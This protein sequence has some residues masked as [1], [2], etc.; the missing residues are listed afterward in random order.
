MKKQFMVTALA[1]LMF[2]TIV[3]AVQ[4]NEGV[5]INQDENIKI[6][7]S[8]QLT[9]SYLAVYENDTDIGNSNFSLNQAGTDSVYVNLDNYKPLNLRPDNTFNYTINAS[10]GNQVQ[11]SHNGLYGDSLYAVRENGSII[12]KTGSSDSGEINYTLDQFSTK[13]VTVFNQ[14]NFTEKEKEQLPVK[15]S[16]EPQVI[17]T[18]KDQA[19]EISSENKP[20][21]SINFDFNPLQILNIQ[22]FLNSDNKPSIRNI[23]VYNSQGNQVS[24]V[25]EGANITIKA[26]ISHLDGRNQIQTPNITLTNPDGTIRV[27]QVDIT[28]TS[29]V[30]NGYI[31]SYNYTIPESTSDAGEWSIQVK[32]SDIDGDTDTLQED[33]IH[34]YVIESIQD[35]E[36]DGEPTIFEDISYTKDASF[37]NPSDSTYF[38]VDAEI[39]VPTSIVPS[40]TV[41]LDQ[42]G[43]TVPHSVNTTS[44]TVSFTIASL[45]SN[46]VNQYELQYDIKGP[47]VSTSTSTVIDDT[48]RNSTVKQ[49]NVSSQIQGTYPD[50]AASTS[51]DSPEDVVSYKL[52]INGTEV[53][54]DEDYN[55]NE[56]DEDNDGTLET[57]EWVAPSLEGRQDYRV[58]A[59]RGFPLLTY[60][61]DVITNKPVTET[62]SIQWRTGLKFWNRN[63]FPVDISYKARMPLRSSNLFIGDQPADKRFDD[64]G[65]YIPVQ[66]TIPSQSNRT[67]YIEYTSPTI[68]VTQNKYD[69]EVHWVNK[70]TETTVNVS[71][72]NDISLPIKDAEATVNILQGNNLQTMLENGSVIDEQQVVEGDYTFNVSRIEANSEKTVSVQYEVPVAQHEYLGDRN[73]SNGNTLDVWSISSESPVARQNTQFLAS[74]ISCVEAQRAYMIETNETQEIKCRD[75]ETVVN[76]GTLGPN[77]EFK[78]G[79][80]H[81]EYNVIVEN[82]IRL[83]RVLSANLLL[84]GSTLL[85]FLAVIGGGYYVYQREDIPLPYIQE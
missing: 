15:D 31:Y 47:Q 69:P 6:N 62:K 65:A 37:E 14:E 24:S 75:Q 33:F 19:Q 29:Q 68:S 43:N 50:L 8:T 83:Y 25:P 64:Q 80:E 52:Y 28:N 26:E 3:G 70:P 32:A 5:K 4:I 60:R 18:D 35:A 12:L 30:N 38:S 45:N 22:S 17:Y 56:I 34:K 78:L 73:V 23:K 58:E 85:I 57:V 59:L 53:T 79:I 21:G 46:S 54:T 42:N 48:G 40:S 36:L 7:S 9:P 16:P 82:S 27:N 84:A 51:F 63:D 1:F 76:V 41:L 13:R 67:K 55:F 81:K 11:V 39:G 10:T 66:F 77:Q 72:I 44:G 74:N 71:F 61:E 49:F 2:S 20:S